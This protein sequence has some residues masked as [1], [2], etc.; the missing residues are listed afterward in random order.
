LVVEGVVALVAASLF[1]CSFWIKRPQ[2]VKM[3]GAAECIATTSFEAVAFMTWLERLSIATRAAY[4][5]TIH[6]R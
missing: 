1:I 2:N 5:R 6:D 4:S 3:L